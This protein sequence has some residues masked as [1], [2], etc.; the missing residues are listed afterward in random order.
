MADMTTMTAADWAAALNDPELL[1]KAL[2]LVSR[3]RP[4]PA[5]D[6]DYSFSAPR[7]WGRIEPPAVADD[8]WQGF[9]ADTETGG[10]NILE[11]W[12]RQAE[13]LRRALAVLYRAEAPDPRVIEL[14][15]EKRRL[16]DSLSPP[17]AMRGRLAKNLDAKIYI[18]LGEIDAELRRY[19]FDAR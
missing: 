2:L 16:C 6:G 12:R 15:A 11:N 10:P 4:A 13:A 3:A 5:L 9:A 19:G 8:I 1:G 17:A 7:E 14:L 18:Q